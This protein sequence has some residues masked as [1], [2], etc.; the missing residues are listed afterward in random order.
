MASDYW[1]SFYPKKII[2]PRVEFKTGRL[3]ITD[4]PGH[5]LFDRHITDMANDTVS[6]PGV[7]DYKMSVMAAVGYNIV[8]VYTGEIGGYIQ[9]LDGILW[10]GNVSPNVSPDEMD[11]MYSD[12]EN[13]DRN[14]NY[15]TIVDEAAL[16]D[17]CKD[18]SETEEAAQTHFQELLEDFPIRKTVEPG[19]YLLTIPGPKFWDLKH[20]E[21]EQINNNRRD[22]LFT[23]SKEPLDWRL[24][25]PKDDDPT[26]A[27]GM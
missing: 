15:V 18:L 12:M 1:T 24:A 23:L 9:E 13:T 20:M 22:T 7:N 17:F 26:P 6:N 5:E 14:A 10:C 21:C 2:T 3:L 11:R 8:I 25:G 19:E 16:W 4:L 27:P